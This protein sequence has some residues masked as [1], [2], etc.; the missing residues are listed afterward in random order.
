M[1]TKVKVEDLGRPATEFDQDQ[2]NL[3]EKLAP[4]S[5]EKE[6]SRRTKRVR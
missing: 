4:N 6:V 5:F 2:I 1:E 3:V